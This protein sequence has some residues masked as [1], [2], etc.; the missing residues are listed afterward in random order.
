MEGRASQERCPTSAETRRKGCETIACTVRQLSDDATRPTVSTY[1]RRFDFSRAVNIH[2]HPMSRR[3]VTRTIVRKNER[4]VYRTFVGVRNKIPLFVRLI[5]DFVGAGAV[6]PKLREMVNGTLSEDGKIYKHVWASPRSR[7]VKM[8]IR[9]RR[10]VNGRYGTRA[11]HAPTD[12]ALDETWSKAEKK[13][14]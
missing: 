12:S 7:T 4:D 3:L 13:G 8:T 1:N 6:G 11:C 10:I 5:M 14:S 2:A 9:G